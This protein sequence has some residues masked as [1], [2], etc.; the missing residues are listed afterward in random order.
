MNKKSLL[1]KA[2]FLFFLFIYRKKIKSM[3]KLKSF[4]GFLNN[5]RSVNVVIDHN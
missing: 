3:K 5:R 4:E 2:F 1:R